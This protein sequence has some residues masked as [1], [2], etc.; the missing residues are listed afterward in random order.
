[1]HF[2]AFKRKKNYFYSAYAQRWKDNLFSRINLLLFH[3]KIKKNSSIKP[4]SISDTENMIS[5][6]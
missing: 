2:S 6:N 3:L 1:M 4:F 5:F